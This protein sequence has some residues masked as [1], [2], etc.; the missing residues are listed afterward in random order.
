MLR[1]FIYH[2]LVVG[3]GPPNHNAWRF[4]NSRVL[5][6]SFGL[7]CSLPSPTSMRAKRRGNEAR[8]SLFFLGKN[9]DVLHAETK[10]TDKGGGGWTAPNSSV[11][12][13]RLSS[14]IWEKVT[15]RS[16]Q[17]HFLPQRFFV[18]CT[19]IVGTHKKRQR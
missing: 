18:R 10:R 6:F 3:H 8:L 14:V 16:R 11:T 2:V 17:H 5:S 1:K 7:G 9:C 19:P 12:S 13:F 4:W 15:K